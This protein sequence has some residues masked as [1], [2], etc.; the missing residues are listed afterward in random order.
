[1]KEIILDTNFLLIPG[2]F[3]I[4]IFEE[5]DR[6]IPEK[7]K[8]YALD[9]TLD[10]L[11]KILNNEEQKKKNKHAAELA[12]QLIDSKDIPII[13][14]SSNLDVDSILVKKSQNKDTII[15][16]QDIILKKRIKNK[17]ITLRQKKKLILA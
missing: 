16:T 13:K 17:V 4:D 7:H 6:I 14:T 2:Q 9:K 10:E 3:N 1:M 8:L 12:I 11:K 5:I 15:A